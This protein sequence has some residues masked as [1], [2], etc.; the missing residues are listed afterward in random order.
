M[1]F[2]KRATTRVR[3]RENRAKDGGRKPRGRYDVNIV[4]SN[5][6]RGHDRS[7][8]SGPTRSSATRDASIRLTGLKRA[9]RF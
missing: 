7:P 4:Q 8:N 2:Y 1:I 3:S 6:G 9:K 5:Y